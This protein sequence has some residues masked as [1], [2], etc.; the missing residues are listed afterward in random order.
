MQ[1]FRIDEDSKIDRDEFTSA[2]SAEGVKAEG[3]TPI[4][5]HLQELFTKQVGYGRTHCPFDCPVYGKKIQYK[6]GD[7]PVAE[8]LC[9]QDVVIPCYHSLRGS[10][11]NDIAA[12]LTRVARWYETK[13]R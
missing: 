3:Y 12:A 4:P 11:L 13:H 10:D 7:C 6:A 1:A 9:K 8:K 5:V 2:V